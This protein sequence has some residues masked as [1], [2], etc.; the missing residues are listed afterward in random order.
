VSAGDYYYSF[1][2]KD[3]AADTIAVVSEIVQVRGYLSSEKTIT[4][5][6]VN[7]L[8]DAPAMPVIESG[9][10]QLTVSWTAVAMAGDYEVYYSNTTTEPATPSQSIHNVTTTIINGLSNG[11]TYYVWVKAKNSAG[12]SGFSPMANGTPRALVENSITITL[13][14]QDDVSLPSQSTDILPGQSR[15]FQVTG[16]YTSYQWYLD[17]SAINGATDASYTLNTASM[18]F[19]VHELSVVVATDTDELLSG[20][21]YV[22]VEPF[23]ISDITYSGDTWALQG[24][25]KR[26]SPTIGHNET[27]ITRYSFTSTGSNAS[28]VIHLEVSSEPGYDFAFVGYLDDSTASRTSN[29]YERISGSTSQTITITIPSA[30]SHFVEIGY[31]KDGSVDNGSDCAWFTIE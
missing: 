26:K 13:A 12:T 2:L 9:D 20:N 30:G 8:P 27:T 7:T 5:N 1:R 14:S 28:L 11:T 19:G 17:G 6:Q 23:E 15:T 31:G 24:D 22:R 4:L 16:S 21:C 18:L 10:S 3:N 29:Y 25:G